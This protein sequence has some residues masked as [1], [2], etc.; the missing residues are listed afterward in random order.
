M[1]LLK[2]L[3]FETIH[4]DHP[5][6]SGDILVDMNWNNTKKWSWYAGSSFGGVA[7]HGGFSPYE[8]HIASLPMVPVLRKVWREFYPL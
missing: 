4:W 3:S 2:A 5:E 1:A 8:V 6:R 7:G